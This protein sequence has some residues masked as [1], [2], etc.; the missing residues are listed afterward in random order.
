MKLIQTVT[1][2]SGGSANIEFTSIP[3][4]YT[5][6]FI[7]VSGRTNRAF[8]IDSIKVEFN[9]STSGL[10]QRELYGS[11]ADVGTG[12]ESKFKGGYTTGAN[13]TANTFGSSSIYIPNYRNSYGKL[14]T[15]DG[16]SENNATQAFQVIA[17]SLWTGTAAITSVKLLPDMGTLFSQYSSASLYGITAGSSGGVTVS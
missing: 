13:A 4:T 11:G 17:A 6:L 5:D 7:Q 1:V 15:I 16:V 14:G 3:Q 12:T 2:G 10:S 9:G 8:T